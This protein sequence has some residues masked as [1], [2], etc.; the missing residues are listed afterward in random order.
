[1]L[2]Q[3]EAIVSAKN[4]NKNLQQQFLYQMK[5]LIADSVGQSIQETIGWLRRAIDTTLPEFSPDRIDA[6]LIGISEFHVLTD[7]AEVLIRAKQEEDAGKLLIALIGYANLHY[8]DQEARVKVMPRATLLLT[9]ILMKKGECLE[10][11]RQCSHAI[12]LLRSVKVLYDLAGLMDTYLQAGSHCI[13][14]EA[15]VRYEKQLVALRDIYMEYGIDPDHS[16]ANCSYYQNQDLYLMS[17]LIRSARIHSGFSQEEV[18]EGICSPENYSR[19]ETG[20]H[21]PN[22]GTYRALMEKM[23]IDVDYFESDLDTSNFTLLEKKRTLDREEALGHY[24][25][26]AKLLMEIQEGLQEEGTIDLPRNKQFLMAEDNLIRYS[27]KIQDEDQFMRQCEI[28]FDC[29]NEEW[30]SERFWNQFLTKYKVKLLNQLA[31]IYA[32]RHKDYTNG[33]YIWEHILNWLRDSKLPL[34]DRFTAT[35]LAMGNLSIFYTGIGKDAEGL[36]MCEERIRLSLSCGRG[37]RLGRDVMNKVESLITLDPASKEA[38]EKYVQQAY[39]LN[40]LLGPETSIKYADRY[41]RNN[42]D[43]NVVWY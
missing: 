6:Y 17:E 1:M 23:D 28:Y 20:R 22:A 43:P 38:C 7:L 21:S 4:G 16:P 13:R 19:I 25:E 30:R 15:T 24:Q 32:V 34:T 42:Y 40:D 27:E 12:D 33:I 36:H 5:A 2:K 35:S 39:Y 9:P 31:L 8:R 41:Y 14:T 18:S 11:M 26:A 37:L 29:G 3:P 10:C